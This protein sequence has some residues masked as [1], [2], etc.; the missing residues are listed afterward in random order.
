MYCTCTCIQYSY[1]FLVCL[2]CLK[3]E[4]RI[5]VQIYLYITVF[6]MVKELSEH[7]H[8]TLIPISSRGGSAFSR[9]LHIS[10]FVRLKEGPLFDGGTYSRGGAY[11][12]IYSN[13]FLISCQVLP[14]SQEQ[15]QGSMEGEFISLSDVIWYLFQ[16]ISSTT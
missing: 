4:T 1:L 3:T 2:S 12:R 7:Q 8:S 6:L 9:G 5:R 13:C 11:L 14:S 10:N 16:C 15:T